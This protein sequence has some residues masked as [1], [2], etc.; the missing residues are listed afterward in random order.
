MMLTVFYQVHYQYPAALPWPI[1][2][3]MGDSAA[4][5]DGNGKNYYF[6]FSLLMMTELPNSTFSLVR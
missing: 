1:R 5:I 3:N 6:T 4:P 2:V